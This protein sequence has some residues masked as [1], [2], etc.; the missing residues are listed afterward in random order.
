M[1]V[2]H[3]TGHDNAVKTAELS[4]PGYLHHKENNK[5]SQYWIEKLNKWDF[6]FHAML[7]F[8]EIQCLVEKMSHS[9]ITSVKWVLKEFE[10]CKTCH[11]NQLFCPLFFTEFLP[12]TLSQ[13]PLIWKSGNQFGIRTWEC[14]VFVTFMLWNG[15]VLPLTSRLTCEPCIFDSRRARIF[16]YQNENGTLEKK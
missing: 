9:E 1:L 4:V 5:V 10:L 3:V 16:A 8:G 7:N 13:I 14:P 12:F 11:K 2:L 15:C 6:L